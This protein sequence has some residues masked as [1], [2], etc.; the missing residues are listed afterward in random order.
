MEPEDNYTQHEIHLLI[1]RMSSKCVSNIS[2]VY[3]S[4]ILGI[5]YIPL[6]RTYLFPEY[7][8]TFNISFLIFIIVKKIIIYDH[9][10]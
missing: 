5:A 4:T 10:V 2:Q 9:R 8:Y 7:M 1:F 3:L 6:F